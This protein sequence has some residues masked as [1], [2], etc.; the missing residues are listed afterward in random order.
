MKIR[1]VS[2]V[3]SG[4]T[5]YTFSWCMD[6]IVPHV[7]SFNRRSLLSILFF[8]NIVSSL[9]LDEVVRPKSRYLRV[10]GLGVGDGRRVLEI[11]MHCS[12]AWSD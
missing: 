3:F 5:G 10:S 11:S 2:A 1:L 12:H 8:S 7:T 4:R 9:D 6:L